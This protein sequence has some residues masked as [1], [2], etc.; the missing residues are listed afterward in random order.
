MTIQNGKKI[1]ATVLIE[2]AAEGRRFTV[3]VDSKRI[4]I[5]A[6][7]FRTFA[8]L[9]LVRWNDHMGGGWV[10]K[11]ELGFDADRAASYLFVCRR[12]IECAL[13]GKC[14]WI[15][16][17][18]NHEGSWR[19]ACPPTA[20]KFDLTNLRRFP[21]HFLTRLLPKEVAMPGASKPGKT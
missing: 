1:P 17:E 7:S 3:V 9:A 20:I 18:S 2:G 19:I 14:E 5:P 12:S 8:M 15:P 4:A 13:G 10:Y 6:T 16:I 21:D 11:T